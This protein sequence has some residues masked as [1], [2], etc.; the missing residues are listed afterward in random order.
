MNGSSD[1]SIDFKPFFD[2]VVGILFILLILISAQL[3]FSQWGSEPTPEQQ[4]ARAEEAR[5]QLVV[6]D[7]A[8]FLEQLAGRLGEQ[9]FSASVDKAGQ[10]VA[11]DT[12]LLMTDPV[13]RELDSAQVERLAGIVGDALKC[14][15]VSTAP[16]T[17]NGPCGRPYEARLAQAAASVEMSGGQAAGATPEKSLR[18]MGLRLAATFFAAAPDV[19][20]MVSPAGALAVDPEVP[21]VIV[22]SDRQDAPA[23]GQIRFKFD[24]I[25]PKRAQ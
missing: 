25:D 1:G 20:D 16:T 24:L 9:G 12:A 3:F 15:A 13:K 4:A 11:V 14:V 21:V 22:A 8:R 10:S 6:A 19:L 17:A 5:R 18:V 23:R 2:L 7:Q